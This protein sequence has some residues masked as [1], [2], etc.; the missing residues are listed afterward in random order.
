MLLGLVVLSGSYR[1]VEKVGIFFGAFELVFLVT[2]VQ[3]APAPEQM[4]EG[5]W[6][7]PVKDPE[8]TEL[9][10]ANVGAVI[11]PWMLFYQQSAICDKGFT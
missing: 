10:A 6:T 2:M 1:K 9:L 5:L 4:W 3:A 7:F 11:M 8:W